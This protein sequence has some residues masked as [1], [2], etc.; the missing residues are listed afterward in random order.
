[1]S[2]AVSI[3]RRSVSLLLVSLVV[4]SATAGVAAAETRTGDT[5]VVGPNETIRGDLDAFGGNVVI[6]GTVDGNLRAFGGNVEI[7]GTVTGNVQTASGSVRVSGRVGGD[8]SA[9]AG[10]VTLASGGVVEGTVEAGAG[11]VLIDGTVGEDVRAGGQVRLG[12]DADV[13]GDVRYG[14]QLDRAD[15]ARVG[16][17]V[18]RDPGISI[19]PGPMPRFP[20]G[21]FAAYGFLVTLLT[22]AVL[23]AAFPR[24][25]AGVVD[26]VRTDPVRTGGIGLL[27]VIAVPVALLVLVVTLV[28]IP[29][30]L[31]GL[32]LF[33]IALWIGALLGRYVLGVWLLSLADYENRWVALLAGVVAVAV[34]VRLPV[35]YLAGLVRLVLFLL[36]FGAVVL[37]LWA[38]YREREGPGLGA[39][40]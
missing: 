35:P 16:G 12:P 28:G 21:A 9:A 40:E 26:R 22:A 2:R 24:F 3:G 34:L 38:W 31:A 5:V 8:L 15:G 11:S 23:L 17:E 39:P 25:A 33:L 27:A 18:I 37:G 7:S 32:A 29:L 4:L 6:R 19:G 36:G 14:G 13:A 10:S 30:A 20:T 1:M